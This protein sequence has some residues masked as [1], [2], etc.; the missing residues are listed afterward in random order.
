MIMMTMM[1]VMKKNIHHN[2]NNNDNTEACLSKSTY[3][4]QQDPELTASKCS[5][6]KI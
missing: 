1:I 2:T 4:V 5:F 6:C 3:K